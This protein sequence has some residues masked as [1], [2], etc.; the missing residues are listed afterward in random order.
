MFA[1]CTLRKLLI[2]LTYVQFSQKNRLKMERL[3]PHCFLGKKKMRSGA[4]H[5]ILVRLVVIFLE[6]E[7]RWDEE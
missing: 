5:F 2:V 4:N 7:R 3:A 1:I 6:K